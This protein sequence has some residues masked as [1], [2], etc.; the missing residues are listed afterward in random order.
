MSHKLPHR[1][2][3]VEDESVEPASLEHSRQFQGLID[4]DEDEDFEFTAEHTSVDLYG[5]HLLL[6]ASEPIDREGAGLDHQA[7]ALPTP[8][9]T[10]SP[11]TLLDT[12]H[13]A[14]FA[15]TA[16]PIDY[17]MAFLLNFCRYYLF[18]F[19]FHSFRGDHPEAW[20]WGRICVL[21]Q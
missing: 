17:K 21:K 10:P 13:F 6:P 11:A 7:W 9:D 19:P 8:P 12:G 3:T 14:S 2:F 15:T 5:Q 1:P 20:F 16:V 18:S 4:G